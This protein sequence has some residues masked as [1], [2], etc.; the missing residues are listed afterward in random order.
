MKLLFLGASSFTGYHFVK[1]ISETNQYKIYCTL[2]KNL[3]QYDSIRLRR[4]KSLN[5]KKN[6]FFIRNIKFGDKKFMHLIKKNSF[7]I[8]CMHHAETLNYNDDKKFNFKKSIKKNVKNIN[9]VFQILNK[10]TRIMISN[11]IFQEIKSKN[12]TPVNNY[13]K[14]KSITYEKIKEVCAKFNLK[15]K[16]IF[17][18]NPWGIYEEKKLNY[19][20]IKNWLQNKEAVVNYPKY[21]R[22]NIHIDKLTKNYIKMIFS[23]SKKINYFPSGYCSLNEEFINALKKKFEKYFHKK[24]YIRYNYNLKHTQPMIR[25][26]SKNLRKKILIKENLNSYFKY[27]KKLINKF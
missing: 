19:Y 1:K 25:I 14:S 8:L 21:V 6:I 3:N 2:T 24:V 27:Y 16:S 23:K 10:K 20:L 5:K 12:Y 18:T 22:D 17:I 9:N 13:G 11:T 15:Y 7:N 4:I 26:N